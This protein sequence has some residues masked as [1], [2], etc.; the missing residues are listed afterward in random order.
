MTREKSWAVAPVTDLHTQPKQ[1][2]LPPLSLLFGSHLQKASMQSAALAP[3]ARR[4]AAM[5]ASIAATHRKLTARMTHE[6]RMAAQGAGS[7]EIAARVVLPSTS[8][9]RR[10]D[11]A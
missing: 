7:S 10:R 3:P 8:A 6:K 1:S 11:A 2:E 5:L 4:V 9:A